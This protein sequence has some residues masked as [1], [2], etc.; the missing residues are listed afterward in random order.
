MTAQDFE[1]NPVPHHCFAALVAV[2]T[3]AATAIFATDHPLKPSLEVFVGLITLAYGLW[4]RRSCPL[5]LNGAMFVLAL[6][7]IAYPL[8]VKRPDAPFADKAQ[9]A[10][11]EDIYSEAESSLS[12]AK[13]RGIDLHDACN[14]AFRASV[15]LKE[16]SPSLANRLY[17]LY[18]HANCQRLP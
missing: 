6:F 3:F 12:D 7:L 2:A 9:A 15:L 18:S 5:W 8:W 1:D 17:N 10:S 14:I 11:C 13:R 16:C 4:N